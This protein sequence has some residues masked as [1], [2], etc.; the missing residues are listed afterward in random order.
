MAMGVSGIMDGCLLVTCRA[1]GFLGDEVCHV[2]VSLS[3]HIR[4]L[5]IIKRISSK[6]LLF[7]SLN[8]LLSCTPNS[9][10]VDAMR[11]DGG[12]WWCVCECGV[13]AEQMAVVGAVVVV[14]V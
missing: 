12:V 4:T 2:R 9:G 5:F 10:A 6:Q 14:V 8:T 13:L 11:C 7:P 1:R 3:R